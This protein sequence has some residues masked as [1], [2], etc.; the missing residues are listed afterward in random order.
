[1]MR[2]IVTAVT[3]VS[4]LILNSAAAA[5]GPLVFTDRAAWLAA[6]GATPDRVEN[7]DSF[8]TDTVYGV[9]LSVTA[10]FLTF[11]VD[12]ADSD[13][14]WQIDAAPAAFPAI[15]SVNGSAF[16]VTLFNT[17]YGG[18]R[19]SFAPVTALGFEYAGSSYS[20]SPLALTTSRADVIILQPTALTARSFI[21]ILYSDVEGFDSLT[22]AGTSQF[23]A[24]LDNVEALAAVP[25]PG[26]IVLLGLGLTVI[27]VKLRR[28]AGASPP[29]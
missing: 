12:G 15:P 26:T 22:W 19:M 7:F 10:G 29:A 2:S 9:G 21:G 14:S 5:A 27:G 17:F 8:A 23:A 13:D 18:T 4:V 28:R 6:V 11:D 20:D 3:F 1:M 25:E 16:A 24:G